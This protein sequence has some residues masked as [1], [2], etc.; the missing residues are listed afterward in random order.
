[1]RY[2]LVCAMVACGASRTERV[3]VD[4]AP[5]PSAQPTTSGALPPP[6]PAMVGTYELD[7]AATKP[8]FEAQL[9][10]LPQD[11]LARMMLETL[12]KMHATLTLAPDGQVTTTAR[13]EGQDQEERVRKGTWRREASD[14][15]I[16]SD[17]KKDMHCTA[18]GARLL[19]SEHKDETMVFV[20]KAP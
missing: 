4:P 19:C 17:T 16:T 5:L 15:V 20:R 3:N 7:V 9:A 18:D 8:Y 14:L 13:V 11:E 6:Q 10:K 2:V 12:A 1:M